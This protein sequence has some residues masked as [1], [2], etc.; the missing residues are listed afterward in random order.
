MS[1]NPSILPGAYVGPELVPFVRETSPLARET[2][3]L[4]GSGTESARFAKG[5]L[6]AIDFEVT[7]IDFEV[8]AALSLYGGWDAQHK[9]EVYLL[10]TLERIAEHMKALLE[11]QATLNQ[12]REA[13]SPHELRVVARGN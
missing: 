2:E 13:N 1:A 3:A 5:F 7:A 4:S 11:I 12:S 6:S 10:R 9:G 8:A